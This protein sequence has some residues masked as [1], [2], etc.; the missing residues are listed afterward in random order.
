MTTASACTS[1]TSCHVQNVTIDS[2][3]CV[4]GSTVLRTCTTAGGALI[5][6]NGCAT[7]TSGVLA[8]VTGETGQLAFEVSAGNTVLADTTT[9]AALDAATIGATTPGTGVF[10][11]IDSATLGATTPGTGVFTAA[12]GNDALIVTSGHTVLTDTTA[13]VSAAVGATPFSIDDADA[14][15]KVS[16]GAAIGDGA[17][18]SRL[19]STDASGV[20]TQTVSGALLV[21]GG[22]S[23]GGAFLSEAARVNPATND[24]AGSVAGGLLLGGG[25]VIQGS[26]LLDS[27]YLTGHATPDGAGSPGEL[28]ITSGNEVYVYNGGSSQWGR[29]A[30]SYEGDPTAYS[31]LPVITPTGAPASAAAAGTA[32]EIRIDG[33]YIYYCVAS[34]TWTRST[35]STW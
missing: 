30:V 21:S 23:I 17:I 18:A 29:I 32:G 6:Q 14:A 27:N 33:N 10:T 2:Q 22:I 24:G 3:L 9:V 28:R 11:S 4:G 5:V 34:G 8:Q 12:A 25:A 1:C 26:V 19:I 7:Q 35:L 13:A 31:T 15:L 16:G 20:V